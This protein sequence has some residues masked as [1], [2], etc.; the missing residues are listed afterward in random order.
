M[1][2]LCG[3]NVQLGTVLQPIDPDLPLSVDESVALGGPFTIRDRVSSGDGALISI[4]YLIKRQS[5][6]FIMSQHEQEVDT[7]KTV[8]KEVRGAYDSR[9]ANLNSQQ[10]RIANVLFAN[11]L[12]FGFPGASAGIFLIQKYPNGLHRS[13]M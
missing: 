3:L 7:W 9:V 2:M 4:I 11:G 13:R 1:R 5:R 6:R 10:Q 12:I 8:Y